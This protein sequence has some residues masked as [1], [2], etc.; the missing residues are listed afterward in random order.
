MI[1]FKQPGIHGQFVNAR[2][3]IKLEDMQTIIKNPQTLPLF[4]QI[5]EKSSQQ[6]ITEETDSQITHNKQ[7]FMSPSL[8]DSIMKQTST[9]V[10][11]NPKSMV[12]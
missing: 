6:A 3:T 2:I 8:H 9:P 12:N 11:G 7:S 4:L 1:L 5:K 10:D